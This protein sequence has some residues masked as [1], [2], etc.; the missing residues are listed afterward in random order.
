MHSTLRRRSVTSRSAIVFVACDGYRCS[1][2]DLLR[3]QPVQGRS[4][5]P[6]ATNIASTRKAAPMTVGARRPSGSTEQIAA[7]A[8]QILAEFQRRYPDVQFSISYDQSDLVA[9]SL[10]S[11]RDAI[12][13]GIILALV[14]T[15][16]VPSDILTNI[17]ILAVGGF[18]C[19]ELGKHL[20]ILKHLGA[21]A[22]FA[23]FIPSYLAFAHLIPAQVVRSLP[24]T[25]RN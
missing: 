19:A 23:T 22:I 11:V 4:V 8:R 14:T 16:K 10:K 20:P 18:A 21:A 1:A 9:E 24:G 7:D 15:G 17:A 5:A 13:I 3:S 6:A 25:G 12:L 2:A